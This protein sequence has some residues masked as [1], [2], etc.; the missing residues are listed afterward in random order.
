MLASQAE[1]GGSIPLRCSNLFMIEYKKATFDDNTIK[2]LLDLSK[3]W[4]D[5]DIGSNCG[6][7]HSENGMCVDGFTDRQMSEEDAVKYAKE[8]WGYDDSD[9]EDESEDSED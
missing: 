8:V 6:E 1:R 4:A 3:K 7:F 5:E 9:F 2:Q